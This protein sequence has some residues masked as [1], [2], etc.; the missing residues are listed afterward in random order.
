MSQRGNTKY[1]SSPGAVDELTLHKE[2][3]LQKTCCELPLE[4]IGCSFLRCWVSVQI[5]LGDVAISSE[6]CKGG[7]K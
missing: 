5:L 4:V 2:W 6:K 7:E 1:I 3:P